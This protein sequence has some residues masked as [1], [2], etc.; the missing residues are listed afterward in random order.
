MKIIGIGLKIMGSFLALVVILIILAILLATFFKFNPP[1]RQI[2][3]VSGHSTNDVIG[4]NHVSVLTWNLGYAGLGKEMDF[5]YDGGEKVRPG[6][7][8]YSVCM[9]GIENFLSQNDSVNFIFLQEVDQKAHRS[10]RDNQVEKLQALL[11]GHE[12]VFAINYNVPFVP[13][14][15]NNPMGKVVAGMMSFSEYRARSSERV[16][17]Q[18]SFKWPKNLFMLNRCFIMQRYV[19]STGKVLVMINTHNSA[20][21]DGSLRKAELELLRQTALS[22]YQKGNYV[23]VG[24]DWNLNPPGYELSRIF[25]GDLSVST[26]LYNA[27]DH[28]MPQHW[29]WA[30]DNTLPSNRFVDEPYQKGK[31]KTTIIDYFLLSPNI[32]LNNIKTI[33]LGFEYSDHNP[34]KMNV[35]LL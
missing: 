32:Q 19:L 28:L 22:E 18:G 16:S 34:V 26:D 13:I 7:E 29:T 25:S 12:S 11:P 24:G 14:P 30:F 33:D 35:Q 27:S 21:D 31:T 9:N 4:N 5:F 20:F 15:L 6:R 3:K 17:F 10:Y 8:Y 2:L 1:A 23:M